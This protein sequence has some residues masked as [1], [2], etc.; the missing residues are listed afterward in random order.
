MTTTAERR[1]GLL[2]NIDFALTALAR[3]LRLPREAP[4]LIFATGRTVGWIAHA[5]E[6]YE[7][8]RMIRPRAQ[9]VG[10]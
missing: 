1:L 4:Y 9:Y 10:T 8:D 2:P 7:S 3:T 6:Q 5:I